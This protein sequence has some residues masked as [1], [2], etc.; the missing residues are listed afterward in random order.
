M[1]DYMSKHTLEKVGENHWL[2]RD[3]EFGGLMN[4]V[5]ISFLPG[6]RIAV[7]GDL[8]PGRHGVVSATGYGIG[9]FSAPKGASYLGEKF[10]DTVWAKERALDELRWHLKEEEESDEPDTKAA[11]KLKELI[12]S[13]LTDERQLYD[14]LEGTGYEDELPGYGYD[15]REERLLVAI[16]HRFAASY[17]QFTEEK[18]GA[19]DRTRQAFRQRDIDSDTATQLVRSLERALDAIEDNFE[20]QGK[21]LEEYKLRYEKLAAMVKQG[22]GVSP[23]SC[24]QLL[25]ISALVVRAW[26][27][28]DKEKHVTAES[29]QNLANELVKS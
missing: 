13:E 17:S 1:H 28:E 6:A 21:L 15:P 11:E 25:V 24:K 12:E 27:L 29:L 22:A 14:A 2:L 3:P 4:S 23:E 10:L 20:R 18:G 16:Q 26:D 7:Y 8:C 5:R 9:W 19:D